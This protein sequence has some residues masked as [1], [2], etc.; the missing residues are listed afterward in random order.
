MIKNYKEYT[1]ELKKIYAEKK[2]HSQKLKELN[3]QQEEIKKK[4][5]KESYDYLIEQFSQKLIRGTSANNFD[6]Y[7]KFN[8]DDRCFLLNDEIGIRINPIFLYSTNIVV[9][10]I[11][12]KKLKGVLY[13]KISDKI[14]DWEYSGGGITIDLFINN[15]ME[16]LDKVYQYRKEAEMKRT[17]KKY[18]L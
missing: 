5:N 1:S 3:I 7:N 16:K 14:F 17:A 15:I 6:R 12:V 13:G 4:L 8:I 2:I 18:N 10:I 9:N 11:Y